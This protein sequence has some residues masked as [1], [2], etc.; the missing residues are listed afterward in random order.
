MAA[1]IEGAS[2]A[3][4]G[5]YTRTETLQRGVSVPAGAR[6]AMIMGEGLTQE[7]LVGS[8]NGNGNDGF[9]STYTSTTGSD[10]R[11][12][13]LGRGSVTVAPVIENRSRL[14]KNGVELSVL[15]GVID[16]AAFDSRFD[17]K[18]DP[19]TGQI[20]LQAARLVD[21]G[22]SLY[23]ASLSNVGTGTIQNLQLVDVNAPPETWTIRCSSV[24][25]DGYG[26]PI[27]GYAKFI[28]RGSVSGL[29]LDGYGNQITWQSNGTVVSN[30]ILSFSIVEGL[31][32]FQEG[33][34]FTLATTA[35]AL[36]AGDSLS[37]RYIPEIY[38]EDPEFFTDLNQLVAKHG[39]P[40]TTDGRLS[41]GAQ[42]AFANGTP[43][44]FTLQTKPSLPRRISYSLVT[45]ASGLTSIDDLTFELPLNVVPDADS[46]I[47]FFVTN[48]ISKAE[49]Q[50]I[51]NKV[52]FF[53]PT[54]TANPAS[55][56]YGAYSWS[57]T[58]I[59]DDS[60]PKQGI[61]GV[62]TVTGP[63]TATLSSLTVAFDS[64]DVSVTRT[65]KI[66]DSLNGN[67]GTYAI[68]SVSGGVMT[69]Y[70]GTGFGTNETGVRFDVLDSSAQSS[71]ILFTQDLAL[72]LGSALRATVVDVK[73]AP[74][75]DAGWLDAFAAAEK[76]TVQMIVPLPA[77]TIS[78]IFQN[79]KVHVEKMSDIRNKNERVL[80]IGAINGLTPENITG[81]KP[82]AVEDIG[83][84][85]GIQ[86]DSVSEILAGNTEDLANYSIFDNYGDSYRVF[87]FYPDQIVVQIG[88]D[89]VIVDGFFMAAAAAGYFS[90]NSS[91]NEPLTNKRLSGF[92]I[93]RNRL[94]SPIVQE[95]I[96]NSGATLLVPVAGGGRVIW[97]KT[98]TISLAAEEQEMSIIFIRDSIA[99]SMRRAFLPYI[100][101]PESP[102]FQTSLY[103]VAQGLMQS[104]IEQ[105][106][107]T[108]YA[109][110]TVKRDD[111]EPRQ[112]NITVAVQ[113]TY[114]VNWIYI[115]INVGRLD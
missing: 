14:F 17:A 81:Q 102:T 66:Y 22:G 85:E 63:T 87:Y 75:F 5:T 18:L 115:K 101:R 56:V 25:R 92:S 95:N 32:K 33:D 93:L 51:P 79:G 20:V 37:A 34:S 65:V 112:W 28:A 68:A 3:V 86:G 55:F 107:I 7:T 13:L 45:S 30:G 72:A 62:L 108:A 27:D 105:R 90:G 71:K 15:E 48:P 2:R 61:D 110:L 59:L 88:A 76:V 73:D 77:Q 70:S 64:S 106:L 35:G 69:L 12:F 67:D 26:N 84:L 46:N 114:P 78:A 31:I 29:I 58:V 52:S 39:Q 97:G 19:L 53:D 9:N 98:T 50:V 23:K 94:Y 91:I 82:A 89:N 4:P 44:V 60:V 104:F 16:N 38:L 40:S 24:R 10:G 111:V 41:L 96:V 83:I 6:I 11:H 54:I 113:P 36:V 43:G 1:N 21:Q 49:T 99:S 74:F 100:G 103:A 57:Y 8:A 42:L 80:L 109:G 47:N